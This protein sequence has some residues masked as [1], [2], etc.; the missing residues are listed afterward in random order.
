MMKTLTTLLLSASLLAFGCGDDTGTPAADAANPTP[1]ATVTPQMPALGGTQIDRAGRPAISTALQATFDG[2]ETT[3]NAAKDAY[4]RDA[5]VSG[6]GA[7]YAGGPP[8]TPGTGTPGSGFTG[9]LGIYDGLDTDCGNQLAFDLAGANT[10]YV[11]L[12]GVLAD[13]R[14][15]VNSDPTIDGTSGSG[16]NVG[17]LAVEANATALVPNDDCGGR[18]LRNDVIDISYNVLAAGQVPGI[19]CQ[20]GTDCPVT[21]GVDANDV[22]FRTTF[23]YLAAPH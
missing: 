6:W 21:D 5:S 1:D 23:P 12:A 15:Y 18:L 10:G 22:A 9:S 20:I 4:N 19:T 13:D 11:G 14:L 3:R 17:Y 8:A 16:C 2:N 7:A